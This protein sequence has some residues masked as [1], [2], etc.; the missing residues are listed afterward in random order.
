MEKN[1]TSHFKTDQKYKQ[2][3]IFKRKIK[4]KCDASENAL[5]AMSVANKETKMMIYQ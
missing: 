1:V 3:I 2:I 5:F 4:Y